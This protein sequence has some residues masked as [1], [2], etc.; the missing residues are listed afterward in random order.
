MKHYYDLYLLQRG[1]FKSSL[2]DHI[3]TMTTILNSLLMHFKLVKDD[4]IR[5]NLESIYIDNI[6]E[7][8]ASQVSIGG[9]DNNYDNLRRNI[10]ILTEDINSSI[11]I[12]SYIDK[13]FGERHW[14]NMAYYCFVLVLTYVMIEGQEL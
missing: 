8:A 2:N 12:Y 11:N 3:D 1:K 14:K 4:K 5:D 6:C 7:M 13:H 10:Q 9:I